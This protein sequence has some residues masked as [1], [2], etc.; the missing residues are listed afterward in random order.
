MRCGVRRGGKIGLG[1][2]ALS[3]RIRTAPWWRTW[4]EHAGGG[5]NWGWQLEP[6]AAASRDGNRVRT[7]MKG[8]WPVGQVG[9]LSGGPQ[10]IF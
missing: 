1:F 3:M 8:I 7:V 9:S 6:C 5:E 10:T 4:G 2:D